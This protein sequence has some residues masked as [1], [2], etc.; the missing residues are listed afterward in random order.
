MYPQPRAVGTEAMSDPGKKGAME[1]ANQEVKY[2][3]EKSP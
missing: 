3:K 1:L 2:K